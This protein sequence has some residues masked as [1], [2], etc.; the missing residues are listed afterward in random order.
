MQYMS[1]NVQHAIESNGWEY[2]L[3]FDG[4]VRVWSQRGE[5]QFLRVNN[6]LYKFGRSNWYYLKGPELINAME[7]YL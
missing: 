2:S 1:N 7:E 3:L 4:W 5:V 6:V